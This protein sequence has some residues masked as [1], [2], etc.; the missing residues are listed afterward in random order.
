MKK[1]IRLSESDLTRIVKRVI[2]ENEQLNK[3][4][5]LSISRFI[6][7]LKMEDLDHDN[8]VFVNKKGKTVFRYDLEDGNLFYSTLLF[9]FVKGLK[10]SKP[11]DVH[12]NVS[13]IIESW[14]EENLIPKFSDEFE[15]KFGFEFKIKNVDLGDEYIDDD[16]EEDDDEE[17]YDE[18][19]YYV[20]NDRIYQKRNAY[21][22]GNPN[23]KKKDSDPM[24]Y[25]NS[26]NDL[27]AI[28]RNQPQRMTLF[29]YEEGNNMF[30]ALHQSSGFVLYVNGEIWFTLKEDYGLSSDEIRNLIKEWIKN[31]FD[32]NTIII[33]A[34]HHL[35]AYGKLE[36]G[37]Q[38][39]RK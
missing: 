3:M 34:D 16:E 26:F 19:N 29:R 18:E 33:S 12:K 9:S 27:D 36:G 20:P 38:S 2:N 31:T 30:V 4:I 7:G 24:E 13:N 21:G 8:I 22:P 1:I 32:I 28:D 11:E 39:R 35:N 15:N 25:L 6:S 10:K 14:A 37:Y 17:N 23:A 5:K